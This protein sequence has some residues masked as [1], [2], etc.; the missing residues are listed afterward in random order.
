MATGNV[1]VYH[2]QPEGYQ[3]VAVVNVSGWEFDNAD[4]A[5]VLE[6]AYR[7]TQNIDGSW[8]LKIGADANDLVEPVDLGDR[9]HRSTSVHDAL[10]YQNQAYVVASSGF[11]PHDFPVVEKSWFA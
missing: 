4:V 1:L 8:S 6:Y 5:D 10:V 11:T 7:W 3:L 9:G 2:A